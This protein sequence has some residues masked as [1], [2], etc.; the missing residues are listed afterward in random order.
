VICHWC[1]AQPETWLAILWL[2]HYRGLCFGN[3]ET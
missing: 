1:G 3:S 2:N